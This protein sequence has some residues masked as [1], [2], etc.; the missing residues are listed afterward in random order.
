MMKLV[1]P[2]LVAAA[3]G[4]LATLAPSQPD[5][6]LQAQ[7]E[8]WAGD[9]PGAIVAVVVDDAGART[10]SAGR[11]S[12]ES[13]DRAITPDT[14]FEMGSISKVLTAWLAAEAL[15][16]ADL[17]WDAPIA[18]GSPITFHG[19]ATHTSGLPRLPADFPERGLLNPYQGLG[20]D[21]V[22]ASLA[23][24][25][26]TDPVTWA[27][28][29]FGAAVLG[30]KAA[31]LLG[32]DYETGVA[33]RVLAPLG[34]TATW[35]SGGQHEGDLSLL[36]PPHNSAGITSRWE[37]DGYAPAG[38]WV[39]TANDLQHWLEAV[40]T[41]K[42]ADLPTSWGATWK[43][44]AATGGPD[45]MGYGWMIREVG[46]EDV[47]WH[48]GGTGGYRSIIGIQR[49]T[50]RGIVILGARDEDVSGIA[51]GWFQGLFTDSA[52]GETEAGEL[53]D[54]VGDYPLAPEFVLAVFTE[55]GQLRAQATGQ[56][57]FP[58]TPAGKDRFELVG[59]AAALSFQ[60]GVDGEIESLI[61]HQGGR[62]MPAARHAA[63]SR[64]VGTPGIT[65]S[66]EQLTPLIGR[67]QLAPQMIITVTR[68]G[69]QLFAQLTGQGNFPVYA[70]APDAFFYEVVDARLTFQRDAEGKVSSL[71]LH[72]GGRDTPAKRL[73]E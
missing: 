28:S 67:Y 51:L 69:S 9:D 38:A 55:E 17:D 20:V 24:T 2:A 37:F 6:A 35:M 45:R 73:D 56:P 7:L 40:L 71:T 60:R 16:E 64:Q 15:A 13:P 11:W 66:P 59:V 34:M 57:S 36:A 68:S 5:A 30:Q 43:E 26:I 63:G 1:S 49:D 10:L 65:L 50:G 4:T 19:L 70:E 31:A 42:S 48:G 62:D 41:D 72:Q 8:S 52:E 61:L 46:G 33:E 27:Y 47:H 21:A 29:N 32:T 23:A 14:A 58:L 44:Q 12:E 18:E 25:E 54:Y 22:M 53:S 3:A 39:S